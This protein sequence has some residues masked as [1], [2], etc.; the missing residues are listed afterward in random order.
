M[1]VCNT[2]VNSFFAYLQ[3]CMYFIKSTGRI[4]IIIFTVSSNEGL[5]ATC[6]AAFE[7]CHLLL[8]TA[9]KGGI[10]VDTS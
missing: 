5:T 3:V 10:K 7:L 6:A 1:E 4:T 2:D 8:N 9:E